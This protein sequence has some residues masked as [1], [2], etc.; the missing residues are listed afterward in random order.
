MK[1]GTVYGIKQCFFILNKN[2]LNNGYCDISKKL[3]GSCL[4]NGRSALEKVFIQLSIWEVFE[5]QKE[6]LIRREDIIPDSPAR[7]DT[8]KSEGG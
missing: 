4:V 7:V 5:Q 6:L 8:S 2:L 3:N 1:K